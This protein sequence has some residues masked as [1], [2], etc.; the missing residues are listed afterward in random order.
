MH[1]RIHI[2]RINKNKN[3][4]SQNILVIESFCFELPLDNELNIKIQIQ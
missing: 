3:A 4:S 1:N 2:I